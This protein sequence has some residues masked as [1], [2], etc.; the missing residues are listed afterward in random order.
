[1]L[2][3]PPVQPSISL[4]ALNQTQSGIEHRLKRLSRI[5][6]VTFGGASPP[7]IDTTTRG[8]QQSAWETQTQ[9]GPY[10]LAVAVRPS[11]HVAW[12]TPPVCVGLGCSSQLRD[13]PAQVLSCDP[14][15]SLKIPTAPSRPQISVLISFHAHHTAMLRWTHPQPVW[16]M[17]PSPSNSP[18]SVFTS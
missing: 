3:T 10:A 6:S 18:C 16:G 11:W 13:A 4:F 7:W 2:H 1:M 15:L 8:F 17:S 5:Q 14:R 9:S 12:P